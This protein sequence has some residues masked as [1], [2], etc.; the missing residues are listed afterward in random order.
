[1]KTTTG[2]LT[3]SGVKIPRHP[4]RNK[5]LLRFI[6]LISAL[7]FSGLTFT[8]AS[9]DVTFK[10]DM[11][12]VK[13]QDGAFITGSFTGP[14]GHWYIAPMTH[15]GDGIYSYETSLNPGA[16]GAYYF[17]HE[18]DWGL[19][20][21]VPAACALMWGVDRKYI[22]P[23]ADVTYAFKFGSCEEIGSQ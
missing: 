19:R 18:N 23:E 22:I 2:K 5:P 17:L 20:E 10:V 3:V 16:E 4:G 11:A 13:N 8:Q 9:S 1:M 21:R 6:A 12:G 14:E 7:L 15:E